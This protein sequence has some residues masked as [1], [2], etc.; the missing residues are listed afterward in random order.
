MPLLG[1]PRW[2]PSTSLTLPTRQTCG[3]N[4]VP[5]VS[6]HGHWWPVCPQ[7]YTP[8]INASCDGF[9]TSLYTTNA[10]AL[11]TKRSATAATGHIPLGFDPVLHGYRPHSHRP[12]LQDPANCLE[13]SAPTPC[14]PSI[15]RT[16]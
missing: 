6:C 8:I 2:M 16:I 3:A 9:R 4:A 5:M 12:T 10:S 13:I 15:A 1:T 11:I 7:M 14:A